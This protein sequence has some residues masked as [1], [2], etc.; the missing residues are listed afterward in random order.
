MGTSCLAVSFWEHRTLSNWSAIVVRMLLGP[1]HR[2]LEVFMWK[3]QNFGVF[4]SHVLSRTH[5]TKA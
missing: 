4:T 5:L 1:N 2:T 3:A